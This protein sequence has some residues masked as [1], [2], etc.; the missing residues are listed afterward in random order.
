MYQI[1]CNHPNLETPW[2]AM[3]LIEAEDPSPGPGEV[4]VDVKVRPINPS[5]ILLLSGRHR[6]PLT[7]NNPVG[8]E[9]AGMIHAVGPG[10]DLHVGQMVAIPFGGTWRER[11]CICAEDAIVVPEGIDIEQASMLSINPVTAA[12]LLEGVSAGQAIVLNAA[13]ST[14]GRMIL[15]LSARRNIRAI[16]LVRRPEAIVGLEEVGA[17]AVLIDEGEDIDEQVKAA[18]GD[19]KV[20]LALDAVAGMA[21]SRMHRCVSDGGELIIFGLLSSDQVV[22][23]ARDVVFRDVTIRGYSRLRVMRSLPSA[24]RAAI[25]E[26]VAELMRQGVFHSPIARRFALKDAAEAVRVH[27]TEPRAGKTLLVS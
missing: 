16:A 27:E 26:D 22:L 17:H 11:M 18:A 21:S 24:R 9:G 4:V 15:A 13:N 3:E 8:I 2:E 14:L 7:K 5:D 10:V 23:P 20:I 6:L 1:V 12:G 25:L 19:R